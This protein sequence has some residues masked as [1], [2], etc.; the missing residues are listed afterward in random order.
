MIPT[1][2]CLLHLHMGLQY[3]SD[4]LSPISAVHMCVDVWLS[5]RSLIAYQYLNTR[6]KMTSSSSSYELPIAPHPMLEFWLA[7]SL[8]T[9][10]GNSCCFEFLNGI[11]TSC[12][13]DRTL[14]FY[15]SRSCD[16]VRSVFFTVV[17]PQA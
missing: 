14:Y 3:F 8:Q 11:A 7:W 17:L 1:L 16:D 4:H 12:L 6:A 9:Y 15:F 2:I 13:A 5:T 10:I